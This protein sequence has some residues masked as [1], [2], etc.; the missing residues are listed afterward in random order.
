MT[1]SPKHTEPDSAARAHRTWSDEVTASSLIPLVGTA[2]IAAAAIAASASIIV[3]GLRSMGQQGLVSKDRSL[4]GRYMLASAITV[5][6]GATAFAF[7][8]RGVV[9]STPP[10]VH[11]CDDPNLRDTPLCRAPP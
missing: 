7:I 8:Q 1:L 10:P 3:A 9:P 5:I 6:L 4:I 2:S 11:L